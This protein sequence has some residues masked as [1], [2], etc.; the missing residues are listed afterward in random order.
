[1]L[2]NIDN[3]ATDGEEKSK[4]EGSSWDWTCTPRAT[5]FVKMDGSTPRPTPVDGKEFV[6]AL[7]LS[8]TVAK[9]DD[10]WLIAAM[11]FSTLTGDSATGTKDAQ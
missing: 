11:H 7:N 8:L 5:E 3:Q 6:F 10:K 2:K 4:P 1:M 9:K